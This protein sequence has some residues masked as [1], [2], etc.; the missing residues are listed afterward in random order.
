MVQR[1]AVRG[2]EASANRLSPDVTFSLMA[3][4]VAE[5]IV[6]ASY[7]LTQRSASTS[8]RTRHVHA[9]VASADGELVTIAVQGDGVHIFDVRLQ[10][11]STG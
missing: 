4:R 6:L 3:S 1:A 11:N 10:S 2:Q 8:S 9:H 7:N 5:P